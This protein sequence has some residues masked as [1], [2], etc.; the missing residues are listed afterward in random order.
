M[1]KKI[2]EIEFI[3]LKYLNLFGFKYIVRNEIGSV[4]VFK[5]IPHR[6]FGHG[7]A[8]WVERAYPMTPDEIKN[9]KK[10]CLSNYDF[11]KFEDEPLLI[12]DILKQYEIVSS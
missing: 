3:E 11:I 2:S 12:E 7:Y 8:T 6:N 1:N 10:V 5:N 4:E 9:R